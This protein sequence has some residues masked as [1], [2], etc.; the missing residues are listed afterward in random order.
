[1][2]AAKSCL[3]A[4]NWLRRDLSQMVDCHFAFLRLKASTPKSAIKSCLAASPEEEL[5]Q[6]SPTLMPG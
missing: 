4:Y 1:M 5:C 2:M 6:R 3:T